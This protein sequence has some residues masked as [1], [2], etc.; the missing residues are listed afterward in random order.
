MNIQENNIIIKENLNNINKKL[1]ENMQSFEIW[2]GYQQYFSDVLSIG[3]LRIQDALRFAQNLYTSRTFC[4]NAIE[5]EEMLHKKRGI[6]NFITK[7]SN[8]KYLEE[9][10]ITEETLGNLYSE[11]ITNAI[12]RKR[13][14]NGTTKFM[15]IK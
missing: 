9:H 3:I 11:E 5:E 12:E 10:G 15:N 6:K 1:V 7:A 4:L 8:S 2:N 14:V 13:K